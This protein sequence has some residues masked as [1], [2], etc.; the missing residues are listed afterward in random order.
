[1]HWA[2]IATGD[3]S[4]DVVFQLDEDTR[5][6]SDLLQR[7]A[8]RII[9][10]SVGNALRHAKASTIKVLANLKENA[11]HLTIEDDGKGFDPA[12]VGKD[13]YGLKGI[14]ERASL[15][16]GTAIIDSNP[17]AGTRVVVQLPCRPES[18]SD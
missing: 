7:C 17:G 14:R 11:L 5:D 3:D 12:L 9:Q 10:E 8:Y 16:D 13:R 2:S 6:V 18:L 15:L 1:M 4:P